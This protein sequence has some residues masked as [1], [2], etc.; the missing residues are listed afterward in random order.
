MRCA[1]ILVRKSFSTTR[2]VIMKKLL[3]ATALSVASLSANA[4][5]IS[6]AGGVS[7][8][9]S[10]F[11]TADQANLQI[12]TGFTQ[13]WTSPGN[14]S[15]A[16]ALLSTNTFLASPATLDAAPGGITE[17][18][19]VGEFENYNGSVAD[20]ALASKFNIPICNGCQ[21]TFAF[22]GFLR[23]AVAV[24]AGDGFDFS[25]AW[26]NV[27]LD[28]DAASSASRTNIANAQTAAQAD[29]EVAKAVDG[30][31]WLALDIQAFTFA[32]LQSPFLPGGAVNPSYN[33]NAAGAVG[34]SGNVVG[35]LAQD[36]FAS[37]FFDIDGNDFDFTTFGFTATFLDDNQ[38]LVNYAADGSG[39]VRARV[40]SEPGAIALFSLGLIGLGL[41]ARRRMNK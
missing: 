4:E 36:S 3:L 15:A 13:W 35:G 1:L 38:N 16:N 31:L 11:T 22:G 12:T 9:Q 28:Y 39:S 18:V 21:L 25:N 5:V 8:I 40:V 6:T 19:G 27:Y 2:N 14:S 23:D 41:S 37:D 17:L 34:F 30:D 10:P 26:L 7:I 29:I 32:P 33:P 24:A 20:A